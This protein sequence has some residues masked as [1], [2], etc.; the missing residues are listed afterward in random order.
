MPFEAVLFEGS[1]PPAY[2]RIAPEA[3]RLRAL[4]LSLAVIGFHFGV[5]EKTVAKA[6]AWSERNR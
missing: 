5:T 6:L 3:R 2:Q 4:N 1:A